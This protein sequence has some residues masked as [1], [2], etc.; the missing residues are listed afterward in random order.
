MPVIVA[1]KGGELCLDSGD[2]VVL[3]GCRRRRFLSLA[4]IAL[5]LALA[6]VGVACAQQP[7]V[8]PQPNSSRSEVAASEPALVR[9]LATQPEFKL[10]VERDY[11]PFVFLGDNGEVQGLSVDA[12]ALVAGHVG[13]RY[14][15]AR[16]GPLN[17]LLQ[18]A[19][20]GQLDVLT[21]LRETAE[22][23]EYLLFTAPYASVPAVVVSRSS[24]AIG[25]ADLTGKSVGVG[26]G[27]AVEVF[28]RYRFPAVV[29]QA[30]PD[31]VAVLKALAQGQL[32]AAVVDL[33]SFAFVQRRY[34][35]PDLK[36]GQPVGFEYALIFAVRKDLP[37]LR[38]ALDIGVR[39]L[40]ANDRRLLRD[41]W[42]AT[43]VGAVPW[44]GSHWW[45]ALGLLVG[46]ALLLWQK[47]RGPWKWPLNRSGL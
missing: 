43:S 36:Q 5:G 34:Q 4:S 28:V 44:S 8:L 19:K 22:R 3:K 14:A 26:K 23:A 17:E 16:A 31:D 33:A 39:A 25:L 45:A 38:D 1:P 29:W 7:P 21:S 20:Q 27:Y 6:C 35:L 32:D 9:W 30:M 10:G 18:A 41:R 24:A 15:T 42:L 46:G 13:L 40:S 2:G 37:Q 12:L 47:R 11:G